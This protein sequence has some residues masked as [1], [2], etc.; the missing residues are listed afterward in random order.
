MVADP[1]IGHKTA[2]VTEVEETE[3][4]RNVKRVHHW[5]GSLDVTVKVKSIKLSLTDGAPTD[6]RWMRAVQDFQSANREW[7]LAKHSQDPGWV[8][9]CKRRLE[10]A[11]ARLLEV[12]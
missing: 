6:K 2:I 12:Q 1:R 10:A 7:M 5:D 9:A 11:N 8:A 3:H 4:G